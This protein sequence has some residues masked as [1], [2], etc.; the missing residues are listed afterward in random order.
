MPASGSRARSPLA[1]TR[2]RG[3]L[4]GAKIG[5]KLAV[6]L[7]NLS[8]AHLLVLLVAALFII[9]PERLP[10]AAATL[11]KAI[12][13]VREYATGAREQLKGEFGTD[14]DELRKPLADLAQLR[15][16]TP[17]SIITKHLFDDDP[18]PLLPEATANNAAPANSPVAL[19]K[20]KTVDPL[21][22]AAPLASGERPP[23][24]SDAT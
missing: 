21:T 13:Q 12:R 7:G 2:A 3:Q 20:P 22:V 16:L 1:H 14:L 5:A 24:D 15:G 9:G 18:S 8:M 11:G 17:K 4:L 23:F 6:V 10:A 19:T